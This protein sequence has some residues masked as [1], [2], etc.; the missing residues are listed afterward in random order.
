[1]LE[2]WLEYHRATLVMKCEGLTGAQLVERAVPPSALSLLGLVRHMA[3][4]E[5]HWFRR[6][7]AGE[8]APDLY[9]TDEDPDGD[10]HPAAD[11]VAAASPAAAFATLAAEWQ[12]AREVAAARSLDDCGRR[13]GEP[14]SLRWV[15][16]HM[17]EEYARHNGHADLLRERLDGSTGD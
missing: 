17:I 10:F 12:H 9:C 3:E 11:G 14:V 16:V 8:E 6:A 15:M 1:M 4:V 7:L 2:A 5:R 13:R